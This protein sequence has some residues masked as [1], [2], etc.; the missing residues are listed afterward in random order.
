M[1]LEQG[2]EK[3]RGGNFGG[4]NTVWENKRLPKWDAS[5]TRLAEVMEGVCD[6][7]DEQCFRTLNRVEDDINDWW[8]TDNRDAVSLHKLICVDRE[9]VCCQEGHG[10]ADCAPCPTDAAGS[11][12]SGRGSCP[13]SGYRQGEQ[14]RAPMSVG[15]AQANEQPASSSADPERKNPPQR[16]SR[17]RASATRATRASCAPTASLDSCAFL[18]PRRASPAALRATVCDTIRAK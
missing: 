3:T 5:E 15:R 7:D 9:R 13:F 1:L 16:R 2:F 17:L 10:G 6:E 12:C 18:T 8:L 4:G 11:V 14:P